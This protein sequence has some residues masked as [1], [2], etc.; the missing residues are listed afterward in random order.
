MVAL[1]DPQ[2]YSP[3]RTMLY[4]VTARF[5]FAPLFILCHRLSVIGRENVPKGSFVAVSNHLSNSDPPL[6]TVA[7]DRPIAFLAKKE[8]YDVPVLKDLILTYGAISVDRSSPELST[9]KAVK[10]MFRAGWSL[11]MFIEGTRNKTPGVLGQPHQGPAYFARSNRVPLLPIG[12]TGT[13]RPW[14]KVVVRIGRPIE[15]SKDLDETTWKIMESLS[16]LTGSALP[17]K[18]SLACLESH[19]GEEMESPSSSSACLESAPGE[20]MESPAKNSW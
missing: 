10:H 4:M 19:P 13:D 8:L 18:E 12:I 11:G 9:F 14:A 20:Q 16:Q 6:L 7:T 2:A 15:P 5:L 1:F 17:P 3:P